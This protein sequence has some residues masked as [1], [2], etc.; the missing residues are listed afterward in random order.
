MGITSML[1]Q[2]DTLPKSAL[3]LLELVMASSGL[4]LVLI[5]NLL[6]IRKCHAN[7]TYRFTSQH[8]GLFCSLCSSHPLTC[9]VLFSDGQVPVVANA[10]SANNQGR[11]GLLSP[12]CGSIQ[13]RHYYQHE[14]YG[15]CHYHV[16]YVASA[17]VS[18]QSCL[19][20]RQIYVRRWL[21][22]F[23][24]SNKYAW[25]SKRIY[26]Q[27]ARKGGAPKPGRWRRPQQRVDFRCLRHGERYSAWTRAVFVSKVWTT[28]QYKHKCEKGHQNC[29]SATGHWSR[30][31]FGGDLYPAYGRIHLGHEQCRERRNL[32]ILPSFGI[33]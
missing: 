31:Q 3:D 29:W 20:R 30:T 8:P 17:T 22:T 2:D 11:G 21:R 33:E 7:S 25:S 24:H 1:V 19:K 23:E 13:S 14:Q 10:S 15:T 32:F 12:S 26:A 9:F 4:L 6:D 27:V 5:N 18:D 28:Q 16:G